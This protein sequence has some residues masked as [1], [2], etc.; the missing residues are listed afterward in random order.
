MS[1]WQASISGHGAILDTKV[2]DRITNELKPRA[3]A[4]VKKYGNM[5]TATA[6]TKAPVDTGNLINTISSNSQMVGELTFRMQD[7]T[8]YGVYQEFG[9][10]KMAAQP[11]F[12]PAIEAWREKFQNAFK[13]LFK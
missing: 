4:I 10:S 1:G 7:G 11:F 2:L 5:M 6:I 9:T 8:E 3:S 13:D 12:R